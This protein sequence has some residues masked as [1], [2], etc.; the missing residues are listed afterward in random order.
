VIN[1]KITEKNGPVVAVIA[2]KEGD[3]IMLMAEKGK[4]IRT[5][6]EDV[7]ETGRAAI[8]VYMMELGDDDKIVT[9]AKIAAEDAKDAHEHA[10]AL[11]AE[12]QEEKLRE[13]GI[14]KKADVPAEPEKPSVNLQEMVDRAETE[15]KQ[16]DEEEEGEK[17]EEK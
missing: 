14:V 8:G 13:S 3:E 16:K 15:Q 10:A 12:A 17:P 5:K 11:K 6:I 9:V 2:V 1:V 4:V 7:R